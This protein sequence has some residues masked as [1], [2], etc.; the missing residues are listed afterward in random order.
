[1][2]Y[3]DV[4]GI[5]PTS[6]KKAIKLAYAKRLKQCRPEDD[7][8]GFQRLHQA[9]K[10]ALQ[11]VAVEVAENDAPWMTDEGKP[12]YSQADTDGIGDAESTDLPSGTNG[13]G[14][15]ESTDLPPD[16]EGT[17]EAELI[18]STLNS[19]DLKPTEFTES[20]EVVLQSQDDNEEDW[21]Q[22]P[23]ETLSPEDKALLEEINQQQDSLGRDWESLYLQANEV[24]KS[25]RRR[26][27]VSEW[28]FLESLSAMSD[29]EF[30]KAAADKLFEAIAEVNATSLERKQLYI[31]RPVLNYLNDLLGWDKK[32]QQYENEYSSDM[33]DAVFPY[34]EESERPAQNVK[35]RRELYYYRRMAAFSID[36]VILF[37]SAAF[38][39]FCVSYFGIG[40]ISSVTAAW[41]WGVV[42]VVLLIP[43]Q[44]SSKYQA[45]IGKYLLGLQVVSAQNGRINFSHAMWRSVV[46]AFCCLAFKLVVFINLILQ[47][48]RSELLQDTLSRSYVVRRSVR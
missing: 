19:D 11:D 15:T 14:G 33:M 46:T 48:W 5:A 8:V 22:A 12:T 2:D 38:V 26:N 24:I 37:L 23:A 43:A 40:N 30:R 7:P 29:L 21:D 42:Y 1:M 17:D 36:L 31:Q 27:N 32:W 3:W 18:S 28:K 47:W 41:R 16:T 44:E 13:T 34:L 45:T 20:I 9:Y 35:Q 6:D 39:E 10:Y 4:L 25:G